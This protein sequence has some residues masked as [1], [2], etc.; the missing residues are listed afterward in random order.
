M[1][2]FALA[3][4]TLSQ[5]N[6]LV[7]EK[8]RRIHVLTQQAREINTRTL[9]RKS[10]DE[11]VQ[12][13]D[14]EELKFLHINDHYKFLG[15]YGKCTQLGEQVCN[16]SSK[17]YLKWVS[18]I[19]SSNTSVLRKVQATDTFHLPALQYHMGKSDW[20]IN[21]RKDIDRRTR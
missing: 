8:H 3:V 15:K 19:W 2:G 12:I 6:S 18:V 20:T 7:V 9:C 1:I 10:R 14:T 11:N 17:V 5:P 16:K 4:H 13:S 21:K